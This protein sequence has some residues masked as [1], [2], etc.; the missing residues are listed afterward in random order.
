MQG[1]C[2]RTPHPAPLGPSAGGAGARPAAQQAR[3]LFWQHAK[4]HG[5]SCQQLDISPESP[6]AA[7]QLQR[8]RQQARPFRA[9]QQ[10]PQ[11]SAERHRSTAAAAGHHSAGR[12]RQQRRPPAAVCILHGSSGSSAPSPRCS[13]ASV[14]GPGPAAGRAGGWRKGGGAARLGTRWQPWRSAFRRGCNA[15]GCVC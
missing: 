5:R 13:S 8:W 11:W 9:W 12:R 7:W 3:Q 10:A 15:R 2:A 4:C 6:P 14:V 1:T